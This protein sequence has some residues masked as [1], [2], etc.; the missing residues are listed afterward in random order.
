MKTQLICLTTICMLLV[1]GLS[2]GRVIGGMKQPD[3]SLVPEDDLRAVALQIEEQVAAGN[4]EAELID[5]GE[6]VVNTDVLR[7][8]VR[9]RAARH[10]VLSELL[11]SGHAWERLNGR[12]WIIRSSAYKTF[13]SKNDRNRHAL[14]VSSEN[15]DRW[16]LYESIIKDNDLPQKAL[17]TVQSI[18]SEERFGLLKPGQK[19][20]T[21][22]GDVAR[23]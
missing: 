3:Y 8:A 16:L 11:D 17:A 7:H 9:T 2:A 20:E 10:A 5:H 22:S 6:I 14:I 21:R 13:G 19:Y 15:R 1:A 23:R 18:F 12:V 4:R